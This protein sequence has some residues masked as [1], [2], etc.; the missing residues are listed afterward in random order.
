MGN[1]D[2]KKITEAA[3]RMQARQLSQQTFD[4][5]KAL[6][7]N[8]IEVYYQPIV[9]ALSGEIADFEA[10][11]RWRR[12]DGS[13]LA[14]ESYV[15]ALEQQHVMYK[16]DTFV[17][18]EV[19]RSYRSLVRAG[20]T[21]V[22]VAVQLS[23][24][25]FAAAD[26][27]MMVHSA[28]TEFAVPPEY[29]N[30]EF[31]ES[32]F[33]ANDMQVLDG[34]ARL[35]ASGYHIWIKDFGGSDSIL[36]S[37]KEYRV[38]TLCFT[39]RFLLNYDHRS[40]VIISSLVNMAKGMRLR[41]VIE[42]V[43]TQDQFEYL[44]SIGCGEVQGSVIGL[45]QP[46]SVFYD[47]GWELERRLETRER[48]K[49]FR[50][51]D[52]VQLL[53]DQPMAIIEGTDSELRMIFA[54]DLYKN[55]IR[56]LDED[57]DTVDMKLND[58]NWGPYHMLRD[59]LRR[60]RFSGRNESAFYTE[61]G[62]YLR[63]QTCVLARNGDCYAYKVIVYN[64]SRDGLSDQKYRLERMLHEIY[65]IYENV[66]LFNV[67]EDSVQS[68]Y[69]GFVYASE[70]GRRQFGIDY[71]VNEFA[72]R[73][74]YADDQQAFRQFMD[75]TTLR[76]RAT[77]G[78]HGYV[79]AYFRT[80]V[81]PS[82]SGGMTA[83]DYVWKEH[84]LL[85]ITQNSR[86]C[87]L[88]YV[89]PALFRRGDES[90]LRD[91]TEWIDQPA[92]EIEARPAPLQRGQKFT[93]HVEETFLQALEK[94]L[95]EIWYQP[96]VRLLTG[97]ICGHE[98]LARWKD[99]EY[100][101]LE[102][103]EFVPVL[104]RC[105]MAAKLDLYA[106]RQALADNKSLRDS[107]W[108][109][110]PT[111]VNISTSDFADP[112]FVDQVIRIRQE[113][114][115]RPE[116]LCFEIWETNGSSVPRN[117]V[118]ENIR[119][120]H[121]AGHTIIVDRFGSDYS[122]FS[123]I[124]DFEVDV[125]KLDKG[126]V[127]KFGIQPNVP[128]LLSSF[129]QYAKMSGLG[130]IA[131]G[132]ET[133]EQ[134]DYLRDLGCEFV[135]GRLTGT[136]QPMSR[137]DIRL[138]SKEGRNADDFIERKYEHIEQRDYYDHLSRVNFM[139][140]KPQHS[141]Y[142]PQDN[143]ACFAICERV[144]AD[145]NILYMNESCRQLM[146]RMGFMREQDPYLTALN[147]DSQL[148]SWLTS[149]CERSDRSKDIAVERVTAKN[150]FCEGA[151]RLL[152]RY[153]GHAGYLLVARE[154]PM[155]AASGRD[156][157]VEA[158]RHVLDIYNRIELLDYDDEVMGSNIYLN[159]AQKRLSATPQPALTHMSIY[160]SHYI[161][162]DQRDEFMK[163]FD[164]DTLF[165]RAGQAVHP[166]VAQ[167]F[168]TLDDDGQ[169]RQQLYT[170]IP[171]QDSE[172]RRHAL[173][174]V[175]NMDGSP[176]SAP[177]LPSEERYVMQGGPDS[178]EGMTPLLE[179]MPDMAW[180]ANPNSGLVLYMNSRA[181]QTVGFSQDQSYQLRAWQILHGSQTEYRQSV[182]KVQGDSV[183]RWNYHDPVTGRSY[184]RSA[185]MM[186]WYGKNVVL[187]MATDVTEYE[188][189]KEKL[190][191][192]ASIS[193]I[194]E[195]ALARAMTGDDPEESLRELLKS[196]GTKVGCDRTFIDVLDGDR[197]SNKYEWCRENVVSAKDRF[198][199][200]LMAKDSFWM[201]HFTLHPY[202]LIRDL[203][204]YAII[205]D[206]IYQHMKEIG[207]HSRIMS[208]VRRQGRIVGIFGAD[209]PPTVY[210]D[211]ATK[212]FGIVSKFIAIMLEQCESVR[213]WEQYSFHDVMTGVLNRHAMD[214]YFATVPLE[215][216]IGVIYS[217]LNG[218][219]KINDTLGHE[220]GDEVIKAEAAALVEVFGQ[221]QVFRL[222]GD[223]FLAIMSGC[224]EA[225]M[226][227][228]LQELD[229][230]Y[231]RRSLSASNGLV[232][233]PDASAG[234]DTLL[235]EADAKMYAAKRAHYG[236]RRRRSDDKK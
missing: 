107:G 229:A 173:S 192:E 81:K 7:E 95:I 160:A 11:S 57:P 174:C 65:R 233:Y 46:C 83:A 227:A 20:R 50:Q 232:W 129:V 28:A 45:A 123:H 198:Q 128:A 195:E 135:Q 35:H 139:S 200:V 222:G 191:A 163:F 73:Y 102:P 164:F 224:T 51:I 43:S 24:S 54:N 219:K 206:E 140:P 108:T 67:D 194:A 144:G 137:A 109:V 153:D 208:V 228:K 166:H 44:R 150:C 103:D 176:E 147:K 14:P 118:R 33:D 22:P 154:K 213:R 59:S 13:L 120:L 78:G 171:F 145:L 217:D 39:P 89:K 92:V 161:A 18:H 196:V 131:V 70:Q 32:V 77:A 71:L 178:A 183:L 172:G 113:S 34:F 58:R 215:R 38:N 42:G 236:D 119:R 111:T 72:H 60:T 148:Y 52:R 234:L 9:R 112:S 26:V 186:R 53:T 2:R 47:G 19:C 101:I 127:N 210:E 187:E 99:A 220:K 149:L 124:N 97:Q 125:I 69:K 203:D 85:P 177:E 55:E 79:S 91:R 40:Q 158:W 106:L 105:G 231:A 96:I 16:L 134:Y 216:S 235:R 17:L 214:R 68:I 104:E 66:R 6:G 190:I 98:A 212:L 159:V 218:L 61:E 121:R 37:I 162:P 4:L 63:L 180:Y 189:D 130:V 76:K 62:C 142:A 56:S 152:S 100:G 143:P 80:L 36:S 88:S 64:M 205:N 197:L 117:V 141:H 179:H 182:R 226:Q 126:I 155:A 86:Y 204:S 170:L 136:V 115:T 8:R 30:I 94:G 122:P 31:A 156:D 75:F 132:V 157:K 221:D 211:S 82:E 74:I 230:A 169:E 49:Y 207:I 225:E 15:P 193:R 185:V 3:L 10:V 188:Q 29:L 202:L 199:N 138:L 48:R 1:D 93:R 5:E 167:P 116:L 23:G 181:R 27:F 165:E 146:C 90:I 114:G 133:Q 168:H 12:E 184:V 21:P 84:T 110:T 223:E 25:D 209:N 201:K 151:M 87:V 175:Q 41:T